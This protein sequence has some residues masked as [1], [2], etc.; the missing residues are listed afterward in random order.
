ME[1]PA[2]VD[3]YKPKV[4]EVYKRAL[5]EHPSCERFSQDEITRL[6]R[7]SIA[8]IADLQAVA[9]K[10]KPRFQVPADFLQNIGAIWVFSGPGTYDQPTKND[11]YSQYPWARWNDR[12]RLN[13]AAKDIG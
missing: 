13:H 10:D 4:S 8:E 2:T 6:I 7:T 11:G 12:E 5:I 3:F 1:S 9:E